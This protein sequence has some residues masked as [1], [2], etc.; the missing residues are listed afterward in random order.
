MYLRLEAITM[1]TLPMAV[2]LSILVAGCGAAPSPA[3]SQTPAPVSLVG[4]WAGES[5]NAAG[6]SFVFRG[7]GTVT[8]QLSQP[9]EIRYLSDLAANPATLD[10]YGFHGGTP[11]DGRTLK[12]II[13]ITGD[14]M[15]M[16]CEPGSYPAAFSGTQ[17][18]TFVRRP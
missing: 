1:R 8:W 5:Q 3:P 18:Q 11:L 10:L 2:P 6:T 4:T 15:R 17:T 13:E 7:D 14:R 12:C 16:D 9:F